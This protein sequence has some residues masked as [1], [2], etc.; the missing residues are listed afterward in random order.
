MVQPYP[1]Y[2][3]LLERAMSDEEE[4]D[5]KSICATINNIA[6][7]LNAVE[8][9]EHYS[10]IAALILH[11]Y[12]LSNKNVMLSSV[13]HNGKLMV[14]GKGVLYFIKNLPSSLQKI[15]GQYIQNY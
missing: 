2:D 12:L 11:H 1:L 7:T 9:S 8:A 4:Y 10:E 13:P 15:I 6:T 5:I 3:T 14:G